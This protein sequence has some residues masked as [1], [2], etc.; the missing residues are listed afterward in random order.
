MFNIF[1]NLVSGTSEL[2]IWKFFF[3]DSAPYS[4]M[5]YLSLYFVFNVIAY[6]V[7]L[8]SNLLMVHEFEHFLYLCLSSYFGS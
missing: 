6:K 1:W 5:M 7:F 8:E 2:H 4:S 3:F